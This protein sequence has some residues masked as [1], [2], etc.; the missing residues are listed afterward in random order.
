MNQRLFSQWSR[1]S[2]WLRP[3]RLRELTLPARWFAYTEDKLR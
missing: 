1:S 3:C 2:Q